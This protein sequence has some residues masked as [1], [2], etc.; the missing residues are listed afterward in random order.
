MELQIL[1]FIQTLRTPAGDAIMPLISSLGNAGIIWIILAAVMIIIPRTRICGFVLAAALLVD[2]G[3]VN[4]IL[5]NIF[6]RVRPY[7]VNTAIQLLIDKPSDFSFP[8]GHTAASFT[9]TVAL[10]LSGTRKHFLRIPVLPDDKN[11]RK[12]WVPVLV[13]SV[14]IA[15]SRMYLYVHY[16][17]DILGGM[18]AGVVAGILGYLI[19]YKIWSKI[20]KE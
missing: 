2:L 4:G 20:K 9:C 6:A 10:Y 5:K 12:L 11:V 17:T 14:V 7:D 3:L 8:S 15:F 19:V 13:L 1:D 16:P 18:A